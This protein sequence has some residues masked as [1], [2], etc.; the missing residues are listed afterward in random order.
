MAAM[1]PAYVATRQEDYSKDHHDVK[2]YAGAGAQGTVF[3]VS[4]SQCTG[5]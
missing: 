3:Q 2:S 1:D 4:A 5:Y